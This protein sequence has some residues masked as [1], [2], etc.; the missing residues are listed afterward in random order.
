MVSLEALR[1]AFRGL[2]LERMGDPPQER[3]SRERFGD[4]P[5][6]EAIETVR[7][8][9]GDP[10]IVVREVLGQHL[11][12]A[13]LWDGGDLVAETLCQHAEERDRIACS[14]GY[15][16][17]H[18]RDGLV[19]TPEEWDALRPLPIGSA[20]PDF[21]AFDDPRY[22]GSFWV[23]FGT[24]YSL[25]PSRQAAASYTVETA[26]AKIQRAMEVPV[27]L[28]EPE[29]ERARALILESYRPAERPTAACSACPALVA[30]EDLWVG[31]KYGNALCDPC[32]T[33]WEK[34]GRAKRT[35]EF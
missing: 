11:G 3:L 14:Y 35:G 16:V 34:A 25:E 23:N 8:D 28:P 1:A 24:T 33:K 2:R 9:M 30:P 31:K 21:F 18:P 4:P 12:A 26:M 6:L 5:Q 13:D 7:V 22:L 20:S 32:M 10:I 17:D 27:E 19:L 29:A 15:C